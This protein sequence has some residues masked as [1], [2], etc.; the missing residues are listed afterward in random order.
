[1]ADTSTKLNFEPIDLEY[2]GLKKGSLSGKVA[3]VTGGVRNIGLGYSRAL[4]WAGAKVVISDIIESI[5]AEAE[6][7]VNTE[8]T[9]DSAL[10]VK[11][12]VTKERD[13]EHLAKTAFDKYGKVDILVNNAMNMRLN[14]HLMASS[15]DD[16]DQSYAISARGVMLAALQFVPGMIERKYGVVVYSA[17]QFH[18]HPPMIGKA[19]YTAGKAAA[20]SII[21]SLANETKCTGVSAF[22]LTPAGVNRD[23]PANPR[24]H[25]YSMPGFGGFIPPETGGAGLVYCILNAEK[26]SGSGIIMNDA[27]DAMSYPYPRPESA[28]RDKLRRLS[29]YEITMALCN[30]GPGFDEQHVQSDC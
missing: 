11:C 23:D 24:Q 5:G 18:Y 27:L 29:D 4:A 2:T 25:K 21:M 8:N 9:P 20:A 13:I 19:I 26:L 15:I 16:L 14:T 10:F 22:C 6:S 7:I 17:T 3:V 28:K 1:M 30:M 12:D